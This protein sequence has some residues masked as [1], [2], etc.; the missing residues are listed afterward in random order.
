MAVPDVRNALS[1][2][3]NWSLGEICAVYYVLPNKFESDRNGEKANILA[4]FTAN[5]ENKLRA[6]KQDNPEWNDAYYKDPKKKQIGLLAQPFANQETIFEDLT[7]GETPEFVKKNSLIRLAENREITGVSYNNKASA[8]SNTNKNKAYKLWTKA[9][10]EFEE[11]INLLTEA[12]SLIPPGESKTKEEDKIAYF[13]RKIA[14]IN[15][16]IN[17][18]GDLEINKDPVQDKARP[19]QAMNAGLLSQLNKQK[20]S[21]P[22]QAMNAG[23]LSQ[24]KKVKAPSGLA[25]LIKKGPPKSSGIN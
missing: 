20:E 19:P 25:D 7:G 11:G 14:D 24:L 9:Q 12:I 23:L 21:V 6:Y 4:A 17:N 13:E 18:L 5:L 22:R 10:K 16:H 2:T 15:T 8:I 3:D 1:G